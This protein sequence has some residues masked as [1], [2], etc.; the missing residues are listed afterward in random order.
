MYF[1]KTAERAIVAGMV[2]FKQGIPDK[3]NYRIFNI[4][5]IKAQD[6]FASMKEAVYRRYKRLLA[7]QKTLPDLILIDGGKG[8]LSSAV[9]SLTALGLK[10]QPIISIAKKAEEIYVPK[11]QRPLKIDLD[12]SGLKYLIRVRDET[13]RWVNTSH[14]NKRDK[15]ELSSLLANIPGL[16]E[17]KIK[18]L[19][20]KFNNLKDI[21]YASKEA[22]LSLPF[23]GEK[24][25]EQIKSYL[26]QVEHRDFR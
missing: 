24:D 22:I 18:S 15:E 10:G 17:K 4:K 21:L 6:D 23:F 12:N 11:Q 1:T 3:A 20:G 25:F 26:E 7:E 16:G 8:Q 13:H 5:S 9:E 19:Y 14:R 2:R